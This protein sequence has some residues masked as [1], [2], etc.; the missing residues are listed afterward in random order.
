[1]KTDIIMKS[2]AA[3]AL[4]ASLAGCTK[5]FVDFN[6]NKHEA[7]DE[8]VLPVLAGSLFQQM[9]RTVIIYRDGTG[10]LDSDYQVSYNL[11]ADTWA[12]YNARLS[13]TDATTAASI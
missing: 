12:G 11:C 6:T 3:V 10:T 1:M 5:N 8:Q 13:V 2:A 4:A 7:T 9:E